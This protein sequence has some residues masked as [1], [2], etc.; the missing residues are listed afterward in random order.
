LPFYPMLDHLRANL[1]NPQG[2]KVASQGNQQPKIGRIIRTILLASLIIVLPGLQWSL[3]GWLHLFLPLVAVYTLGS[4]GGYTGKRL[5]IIAVAISLV[6]YLLQN[7]F[8][9]FIFSSALL[10]SGYVLFF[11]A[12]R[13]DPPPLS[14]LKSA[15]ALAAGWVVILTVLSFGAEVSAY[16]QLL[17]SLDEGIAEA[18]DYYR[19]SSDISADALIMLEATLY[20]MQV[21]VPVIMPAILGSFILVI[22]WFTMVLGN[23]LLLKTSGNSPWIRYR[24]W[25][26]PEKIIW[27]AIGTGILALLPIQPFRNIGINCLV[28]LSIVY[29]F[30]GMS[31]AVFFMNKWNVPLLLRSFFYV[32]IIFQSFGTLLLLVSGI[33]DIWFDFRKLKQEAGNNQST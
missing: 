21:I 3:F 27:I 15:L 19:Q 33:A 28:L 20:R 2:I 12:E 9:L 10:F 8:D 26:L 7:N 14:G 24:Y 5:L 1:G 30:Q 18:L 32:M 6:V 23:M 4:Y 22:T 11:S 13:Q 16:G 31:I 29:C 17:S 25:Q